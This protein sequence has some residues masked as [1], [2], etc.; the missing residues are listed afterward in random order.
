MSRR[1]RASRKKR[2]L[3]ITAI[4]AIAIAEVGFIIA[5]IGPTLLYKQPT[6][7]FNVFSLIGVS[8]VNITSYSTT[9]SLMNPLVFNGT[10]P[11]TVFITIAPTTQCT[12]PYS[13]LYNLTKSS[14]VI[15][16]LLNAPSVGFQFITP[17]QWTNVY[18]SMETLN[19]TAP[20][21]VY[22]ATAS[23]LSYGSQI[24]IGLFNSTQALGILNTTTVIKALNSGSVASI[25]P[26]VIISRGNG[27]LAGYLMGINALN[28]SEIV[29]L[30]NEASG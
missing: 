16:V 26:M 9:P 24:P 12:I 25:L 21:G 18:F 20:P 6:A 3:F 4:V 7:K 13:L 22:L 2:R 23:W 15:L 27:T 19:C 14:S 8:L 11:V 5:Y 10:K 28:Y 30:V 29:K 1:S 17:P